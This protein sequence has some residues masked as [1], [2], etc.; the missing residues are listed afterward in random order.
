MVPRG[1]VGYG[2]L[3]YLVGEPA[4]IACPEPDVVF[5]YLGRYRPSDS[6]SMLQRVELPAEVATGQLGVSRH[7]LVV[8]AWLEDDELVVYWIHERPTDSDNWL[9]C[10]A[11]TFVDLIHTSVETRSAEPSE[12]D[13]SEHVAPGTPTE[14]MVVEAWTDVLR[15]SGPPVGVTDSFFALGGDS[16]HMIQIISR[17]RRAVGRRL[18]LQLMLHRTT[19]RAM[20]AAID[21]WVTTAP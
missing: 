12:M 8:N 6:G 19:A 3:R 2:A 18:P 14:M 13:T 16:I 21:G 20:A 10:A 7:A 17:L 11:D 1:G 9:Y 4:I 15:P 5:T